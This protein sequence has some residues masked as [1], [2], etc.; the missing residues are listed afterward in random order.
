A[1]LDRSQ[2]RRAGLAAA[3]T[4]VLRDLHHVAR[5]DR[6]GPVAGAAFEPGQTEAE[7]ESAFNR[8]RGFAAERREH[9]F[10]DRRTFGDTRLRQHDREGQSVVVLDPT[11]RGAVRT[12]G[13]A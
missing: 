4:T 9:T 10:L 1:A 2:L 8:H 3:L 13:L 11:C 5:L 6:C 12:P 7:L